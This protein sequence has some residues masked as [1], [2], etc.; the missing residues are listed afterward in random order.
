MVHVVTFFFLFQFANLILEEIKTGII[1]APVPPKELNRRFIIWLE[2]TP[3]GERLLR[4]LSI[5]P[6][7]PSTPSKGKDF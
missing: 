1:S 7:T 6:S 3:A 2:Q 4:S 5:P